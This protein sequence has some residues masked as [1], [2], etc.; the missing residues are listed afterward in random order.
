MTP[1]FCAPSQRCL[2]PGG[3]PALGDRDKEC[4]ESLINGVGWPLDGHGEIIGHRGPVQPVPLG[5]RVVTSAQCGDDCSDKTWP[6]RRQTGIGIWL[7][8]NADA[9]MDRL[10]E[11]ELLPD[12]AFW[13]HTPRNPGLCLVSEGLITRFNTMNQ[14]PVARAGA[15]Q[16]IECAGHDG[17]PVTLDGR[18]SSDPD[19]DPL[20][21]HWQWATGQ[22]TGAV[23]NVTLPKGTHCITLTVRDPQRTHRSG[24]HHRDHSRHDASG[25]QRHTHATIIMAPQPHVVD[26]SGQRR[27]ARSLRPRRRCKTNFGCIQSAGQ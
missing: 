19:D 2:D 22:A 25:T 10:K 27:G 18:L 4:C 20:E 7:N 14:P 15:D 5:V 21:F 24:C 11:L 23:V 1:E 17:T 3:W 8:G 12:H 16:T 26:H 13:E 9:R 6:G